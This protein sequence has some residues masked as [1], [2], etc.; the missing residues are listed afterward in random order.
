MLAK[1][2][3]TNEAVPMSQFLRLDPNIRFWNE[4]YPPYGYVD[5]LMNLLR[6]YW[7][8]VRMQ[9]SGQVPL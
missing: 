3:H 4:K 2:V 1:C 6:S 5:E 7:S 9:E 8:T